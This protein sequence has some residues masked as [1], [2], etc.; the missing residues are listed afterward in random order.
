MKACRGIRGA[1][2]ADANT[3]EAIYSATRDMLQEL[4]NLNDIN[5]EQ[6][7]A[8]YFTV[9]SD[10]DAAFPAA[11]ARQ[12]GWNNVAL[13]CSTEI[14]V[15]DSMGRCIRVMILYNTETSQEDIV[16]V[17]LKGT[18]VLRQRGMEENN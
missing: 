3:D 6:V 12:L 11:A 17:Y 15:P 10:L 7:A 18:D 16:N 13:M 4:I 2:T 1:T 9:T 14:P 8:A 5:Q